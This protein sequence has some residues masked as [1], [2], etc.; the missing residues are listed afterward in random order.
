MTKSWKTFESDGEDV[1]K[2][3]AKLVKHEF[4][5]IESIEKRSFWSNL[6]CYCRRKNIPYKS[7]MMNSQSKITKELDLAKF[8]QRQRITMASLMALL[9]G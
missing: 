1:N 3:L 2:D 6:F 5:S 7:W 9:S 8:I 4:Y